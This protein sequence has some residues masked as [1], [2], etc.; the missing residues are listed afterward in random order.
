M[1]KEEEADCRAVGQFE[2]FER[3][4]SPSQNSWVSH[5]ALPQEKIIA[6]V[7]KHYLI[8]AL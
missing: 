2:N 3:E 8:H 5:E 6:L 7:E 1:E 4:Q